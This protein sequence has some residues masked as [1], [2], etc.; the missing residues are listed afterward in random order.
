ISAALLAGGLRDVRLLVLPEEDA[1]YAQLADP[2]DR[3]EFERIFWARRD[4][5]PATPAN[6]LQAAVARARAHADALYTRPGLKGADTDCGQLLVLLGEPPEIAGRE[7]QVHFDNAQ[8]MRGA[9]RPEIWIYRSRPGDAVTFTGGELRVSLDEECRF[10]EGARV[11]EDLLRVARSRVVQPRLGYAKTADGHLVR[12]EDMRAALAAPAAAPVATTRADFPLTIEPKLLLRTASGEAYAAGLLRAE[13]GLGARNGAP[14][15]PI[16]ATVVVQAEDDS[17]RPVGRHERAARGP[18]GADGAFVASYGVPLK[19]GRY[20]LRV[21]LATG[22]KASL[23][24]TKVDVPDFDAPGLKLGSLLVYPEGG[25]PSADAQD[26]YSAFTV[27]ALRLHPRLGNV[28]TTADALHAVCVLYG[29]QADPATGKVSLRARMSLTKDG[30]PVAMGQPET[31]D[32]AS[33]VVSVGPVPLAGYAP[34]RYVA[35][36]EAIDLV[37]GKTQTGEAA[38]EIAP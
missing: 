22:E 14:V 8:A 31:F 10:A 20:V 25:E 3:A 1:T 28:F 12:L 5:E 7:A 33:A 37:S 2:A 9:R 6:E 26:P 27:G 38:F 4:P 19:P 23:V 21:S 13:L 16:A 17:G 30:Q 24:T 11:R 35:K 34:G 36:V 15:P 32:T 18:V 29:G